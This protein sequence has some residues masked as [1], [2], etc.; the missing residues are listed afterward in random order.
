MENFLYKFEVI[1]HDGRVLKDEYPKNEEIGGVV[2]IRFYTNLPLH[3]IYHFFFGEDK[4]KLARFF[5][6][7]F[8]V[9]GKG[10]DY[11]YIVRTDS[12]IIYINAYTGAI[13]YTDDVTYQIKSRFE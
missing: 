3:P 11:C 2:C 6:R 8:I 12:H 4:V 13:V 1:M 5:G 9:T 7:G 10:R